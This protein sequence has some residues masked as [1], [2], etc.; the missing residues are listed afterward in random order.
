MPVDATN[1]PLVVTF[2]PPPVVVM[3]TTA[4]LTPTDAEVEPVLPTVMPVI[5]PM[6]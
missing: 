1:V 6:P 4:P 2:W 5:L 3:V